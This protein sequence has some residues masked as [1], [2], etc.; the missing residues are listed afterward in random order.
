MT[1]ITESPDPTPPPDGYEDALVSTIYEPIVD[2][3]HTLMADSGDFDFVASY[4][5]E[6]QFSLSNAQLPSVETYPADFSFNPWAIGSVFREDEE[7]VTIYTYRHYKK[8]VLS[9]GYYVAEK[10]FKLVIDNRHIEVPGGPCNVLKAT[11]LRVEFETE[12]DDE[13]AINLVRFFW[14]AEVKRQ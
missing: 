10:L 8:V 7:W 4:W 5:S 2:A 1:H 14:N 13:F 3:F 9:E 12:V 6:P 11:P